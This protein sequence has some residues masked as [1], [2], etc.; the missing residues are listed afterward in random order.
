MR[1]KKVVILGSTGSI[2]VNTLRVIDRLSDR[3]EVEGLSAYNNFKLAEKQIKKYNP[4]YAAL[5]DKGCQYLSRTIDTKRTKIL[6][7]EKDLS[8]LVA[9]KNVDIV[10]IAMR[11]SAALAPFLSAIKAG[12][13]VAPA[14]KEAL[15]IAG[16][17]LMREAK[18][19]GA[20]IVPVDSEQS[21]VFQCLNGQNRG[22]LKK[23]ILTASGGALLNTPE[24]QFDRLTIKEIL[25]HPR[26]NM[27]RKITVDSA[28]LMNKGFEVLEA[29]NL[30]GLDITEIEVIIHPEA[31]IHSMVEFKDGSVLAQLGITDM[32]LP[33][34]YAL[35]Y[36]IRMESGLKSMD[37]TQIKQL[38]FLKPDINKF[39]S[40]NLAFYV[41]KKG[42]T[43][44]SVLNASDEEAVD[45]YLEGKIKFSSIF[46]VVEKVVIKHKTIKTPGLD[47]IVQADHWA[48]LE[49]RKA[50]RKLK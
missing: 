24:S 20:V 7:V 13:L 6:N 11:S 34:Q 40:L 2:G 12:K 38:N 5:S 17:L 37:F 50:L 33:I 32:R 36:P 28:T 29:K 9:Q 14:N 41:A 15:V 23:V 48:R 19:S 44:P 16:D 43:L 35:T 45:A 4:K 8:F 27:G 39:P 3:F 46:K 26:W 25:N 47:E 31:I 18:R 10:V 49:A 1:K 30:F 22:E 21:A 42:G